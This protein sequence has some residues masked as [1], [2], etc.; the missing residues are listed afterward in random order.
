MA[1]TTTCSTA[2]SLWDKPALSRQITR[3]TK[4]AIRLDWR[5][6][7]RSAYNYS[8]EAGQAYRRLLA[9][10]SA[11]YILTSYS[12]DGMIPLGELLESNVRRGH[13]SLVMQGY[14]RYRVSSQRFSKKPMNVEFVLVLDTER[15]DPALGGQTAANDSPSWSR[16]AQRASRDRRR[17]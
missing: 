11:R 4:A 1:A 12:T 6:E 10:I 8:D 7:R 5:T 3:G 13:V 9:T 15:Q 14:K 2:S 17:A 16:G